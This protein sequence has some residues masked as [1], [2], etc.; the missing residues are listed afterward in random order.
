MLGA[1]D[2]RRLPLLRGEGGG[3]KLPILIS[4][5]PTKGGGAIKSKK[6]ADVVFGWPLSALSIY[7]FMP[8]RP[9]TLFLPFNSKLFS[10][11]FCVN[12]HKILKTFSGTKRCDEHILLDI[13]HLY[14]RRV[15]L[16]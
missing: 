4:K 1:F 7:N 15:R 12:F 16:R 13:G 14:D 5:L 6:L 10:I 3:Q 8:L 11:S 2:K 9:Y